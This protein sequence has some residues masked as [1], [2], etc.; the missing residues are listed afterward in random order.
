MTNL[1]KKY[2][3]FLSTQEQ[4]KKAMHLFASDFVAK[5]K[6]FK[7]VWRPAKMV[8]DRAESKQCEVLLPL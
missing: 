4:F 3:I 6:Y 1:Y 2:L 5:I 7:S 8:A